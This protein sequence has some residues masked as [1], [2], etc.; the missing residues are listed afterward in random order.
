MN[1]HANT[2]ILPHFVGFLIANRVT[3]SRL[4]VAATEVRKKSWQQRKTAADHAEIIM[5]S[6][7]LTNATKQHSCTAHTYARTYRMGKHT[8]FCWP[9]NNRFIDFVLSNDHSDDFEM[10]SPHIQIGNSNEKTSSSWAIKSVIARKLSYSRPGNH[11]QKRQ[12]QYD[13]RTKERVTFKY[14]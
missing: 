10:F 9:N 4:L 1:F 12:Q 8:N 14:N 11:C 7:V 5:Q 13:C 6:N 3:N 2:C